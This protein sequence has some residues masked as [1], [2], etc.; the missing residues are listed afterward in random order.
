VTLP[1]V[2]HVPYSGRLRWSEPD[3]ANASI[4]LLT[5]TSDPA[6]IFR[7]E[8]SFLKHTIHAV[9]SSGLSCHSLSRCTPN[10]DAKPPVPNTG[11]AKPVYEYPSLV[12]L[13]FEL[14]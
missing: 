8:H 5:F 12:S 7:A 4:E 13:A 6:S 10:N 9:V 3:T 1:L 2:L 11:Y 14:S